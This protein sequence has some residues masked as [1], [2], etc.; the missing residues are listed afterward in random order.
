VTRAEQLALVAHELRSPVAALEALAAGAAAARAAGTLDHVLALAVAAG[1]DVERL[2]A[3]TEPLS[4]RVGPVPVD[5]LLQAAAARAD[6]VRDDLPS[7]AI[8]L[9]DPTRLRQLLGNL[10]ANARR[11]GSVVAIEARLGSGGSILVDVV[12]DGPGIEP[13]LDPFVRGVSGAGS[14]GYG[15]WL[16]RGIAEAH[17]GSLD[18]VRGGPGTRFRLVL[19]L[20]SDVC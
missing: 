8:V 19:P 2:V 4:V 15:L 1:R 14:T 10:V 11:H 16:A 5:E 7:G 3:D 18:L 20:A 13:A 12:D 17:G 9:G 6:L